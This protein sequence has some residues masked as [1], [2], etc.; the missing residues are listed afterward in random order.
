MN[1]VVAKTRSRIRILLH[2]ITLATCHLGLSYCH[3]ERLIAQ[4]EEPGPS[5]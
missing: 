4:L 5:R 2:P 3:S 1:P